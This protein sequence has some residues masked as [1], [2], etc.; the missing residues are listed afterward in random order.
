MKKKITHHARQRLNERVNLTKKRTSIANIAYCKGLTPLQYRGTFFQYLSTKKGKVKV[1]HDYIYIFSKARKRLITVFPIPQKY[2]PVDKYKIP[3]EIINLA[4]KI[5]S[6]NSVNVKIITKDNLIVE[7]ILIDFFR[8]QTM[9]KVRIKKA[10]EIVKIDIDNI[11][12]I[13]TKLSV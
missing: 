3:L 9:Q 13:K 11:E 12:E 8:P 2:L 10:M 6:L 1:Y 4:N 7:G 5:N